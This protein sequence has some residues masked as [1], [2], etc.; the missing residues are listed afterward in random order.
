[1]LKRVQHDNGKG[2]DFVIPISVAWTN[3]F[4]QKFTGITSLSCHPE[5]VSGSKTPV[6]RLILYQI[7]F[8]PLIL[9]FLEM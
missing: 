2:R 9:M 4:N 1:M 5:L 8:P 7:Y 6:I 3:Y